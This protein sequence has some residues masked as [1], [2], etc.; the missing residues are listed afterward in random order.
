MTKIRTQKISW[1]SFLYKHSQLKMKM[2]SP[3]KFVMKISIW[4]ISK[5]FNALIPTNVLA[6]AQSIYTKSNYFA[7]DHLHAMNKVSLWWRQETFKHYAFVNL[8]DLIFFNFLYV[9]SEIWS[10]RIICTIIHSLG[11]KY[12]KFKWFRKN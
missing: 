11:W 1:L 2:L 5:V 8:T 3:Q 7:I 4:K 6:L 9:L 12:L 10:L